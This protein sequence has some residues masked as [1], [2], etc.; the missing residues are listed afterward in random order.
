MDLGTDYYCQAGGGSSGSLL[1]VTHHR[2]LLGCY[3]PSIGCLL[4]AGCLLTRGEGGRGTEPFVRAGDSACQL[5]IK[6]TTNC[7]NISDFSDSMNPLLMPGSTEL[8]KTFNL[9]YVRQPRSAHGNCN[10]NP[11]TNG[12]E[13]IP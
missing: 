13:G 7:Y 11:L 1:L 2:G 4:S 8:C 5:N 10:N 9:V 12:V 6:G 3:I